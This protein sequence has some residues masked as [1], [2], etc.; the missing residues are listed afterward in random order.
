[1]TIDFHAHV[2]VGGAS[3]PPYDG[4]RARRSRGEFVDVG[5]RLSR[6]R[7]TM[8]SWRRGCALLDTVDNDALLAAARRARQPCSASCAPA[9]RP[10][11]AAASCAR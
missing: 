5:R 6:R 11:A 10:G 2:I 1:M 7:S 8:S 4:R 9:P 3:P